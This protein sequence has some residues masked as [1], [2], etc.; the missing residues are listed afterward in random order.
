MTIIWITVAVK[1]KEVTGA[2]NMNIKADYKC[3]Y[4]YTMQGS[5]SQNEKLGDPENL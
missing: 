1:I 4:T 5:V 2:G 3:S